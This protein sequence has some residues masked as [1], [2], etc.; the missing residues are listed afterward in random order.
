MRK[1]HK[2]LAITA[3][4]IGLPSLTYLHKNDYSLT[5]IGI[6]RFA[7]AGDMVIKTLADYKWS[8]YGLN[9]DSEEY[10]EELSKAHQRGADRL[11]KLAR[12]NGGIF[13]KMG[14]QLGTLQYLLPIEYTSTLSVLH[15]KAPESKLSDLEKVFNNSLGTK[16]EEVFVDFNTQPY[17]VA[18]LA[19][20]YSARL[21]SSGEKVAVKIQHP[22]VKSRT[23]ID[24]ATI[25]VGL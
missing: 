19:Q 8:L 17:G 10:R 18:S 4:G 23:V 22:F 7:R 14:Q 21:K 2:V 6:A 25:E 9:P 11:L 5:N 1:L 16:L 3:I 15:S 13:I 12:S 20:V 24:L